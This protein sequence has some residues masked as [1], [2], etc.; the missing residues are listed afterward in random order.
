MQTITRPGPDGCEGKRRGEGGENDHVQILTRALRAYTAGP[1]SLC[2]HATVREV[3]IGNAATTAHRAHRRAALAWIAAI[4]ALALLYGDALID[5]AKASADPY[6]FNGDTR[7][8]IYPFFRYE[9]PTLFRNDLAS[10]YYL[11]NYPIGY[12][13]MYLAV[14]RLDAVRTLSRTL[15]YI[16]L[17]LTIAGIALAAFRLAGGVPAWFTVALCLAAPYFL[18]RMVGG[19]PRSFAFPLI[20]LA[21]AAVTASRVIPL[22]A[23]SV[24]AAAFY[25]PASVICGLTLALHLLALPPAMRGVAEGWSLRKRIAVLTITAIAAATVVIPTALAGREYGSVLTPADVAEFPEIGP[26]GR[27]SAE[28]RA[29]F[30]SL[31]DSVADAARRIVSGASLSATPGALVIGLVALVIVGGSILARKNSAVVRGWLPVAAASI[32]YLVA[33][34]LAPYFYLPQRYVLYLVPLFAILVTPAAISWLI[35]ATTRRRTLAFPLKLAGCAVLLLLAGGPDSR[36]GL[37]SYAR[38]PIYDYVRSLPADTLI[39]AWPLGPADNIPL[40][41]RRPVL[42][43][44]ESHQVFHREYAME[45]RRRVRAIIDALYATDPKPLLRLQS[46]FGVDFLLVDESHLGSSPPGYFAPF[47]SWIREAHASTDLADLE[48]RRQLPHAAVFRDGS[49]VLLDLRRLRPVQ[50]NP[51]ASAMR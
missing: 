14:A 34:P 27:Y 22:A 19:L 16:L 47:D 41:T 9:D 8:Q 42:V 40:L 13:L 38:R 4:L 25:A 37:D 20:A 18:E 29:P 43:H 7:Q 5:H 48:V 3:T 10:S 39:A 46:D 1:L 50:G 15:P 49:L 23:L 36:A 6:V 33:V 35:D 51:D 21:F 28:D 11:D 2:D 26:G 17:A 12:R 45:M 44:Y 31:P 32:A 30:P 24:I